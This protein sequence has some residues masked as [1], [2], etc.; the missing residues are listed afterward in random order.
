VRGAFAALL[1]LL[2]ALAA[3]PAAAAG[4]P[5]PHV[6]VAIGVTL[7]RGL[8][9]G[10]VRLPSGR[11]L[12]IAVPTAS[13]PDVL[14]VPV[15]LGADGRYRATWAGIRRDG[16]PSAGEVAFAIHA[17]AAGPAA[18]EARDVASGHEALTAAGRLL[19][20]SGLAGLAGLVGLRALVVGPSWRAGGV[21]PP[22]GAPDPAAFRERAAAALR[23][24]AGRWWRAWWAL[25][26]VG[27]AGLVLA[28]AAVLASAG[29]G[30]G[31]LGRLLL[32]TRWGTAWLVEAAALAIA[33]A[34]ALILGRG[35]GGRGP[36]LAPGW[37]L[38]LGGP[39]ALAL[40]AVSWSGHAAVEKVG[41]DVAIDAVHNLATAAWLGGLAAL[42]VVLPPTLRRLEPSDRTR[43]AAGVVVRFS[44]LALTA[45]GVL[46]ATGV[47]R[48]L[49]EVSSP[50][51]LL[52]TGYGNALL[53][54][55]LIFVPL[56]GAGAYNRMVLH[57]RLERAAIGL[58][59]DDR[60]AA[61]RLRRSVG[62]E[63]ALAGALMVAVAALVALPPPA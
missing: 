3:L 5:P 40:I 37:A 50:G 48:A 54:K 32:D 42:A 22:V 19:L 36:E 46:V 12:P 62:A 41:L 59:P 60:G 15:G 30:A 51:D 8:F 17:G 53:I 55:L 13:D 33:A 52:D 11:E 39:P 58:D 28:P 6:R 56:L 4:A 49:V 31:D 2:V 23:A 38:A 47:Y 21:A 34:A 1:A 24:A 45:V 44:G 10:A 63:L 20:L 35:P 29:R 14:V 25:A 7:D 27:A 43:L 26:A 9:D 18:V 61:A 16:R 57:P